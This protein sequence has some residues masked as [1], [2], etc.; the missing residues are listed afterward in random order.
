MAHSL[1]VRVPFLDMDVYEM[2]R[3][4]PHRM[5]FHHGITKYALRKAAEGI[6]PGQV[7]AR[8]KLGFPV[9]I[10]NW[11]REEDWYRQVREAFSGRRLPPIS[12][13]S[14]SYNCWRSTV[15]ERRT[16]AGKY[17]RFIAFCCGIGYTFHR[18][19][20]ICVHMEVMEKN[21][22]ELFLPRNACAAGRHG[23]KYGNG[24][25]NI[26]WYASGNIRG[27]DNGTRGTNRRRSDQDPD[28]RG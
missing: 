1:E 24:F 15:M 25:P 11:L 9:P 17:G 4:L 13:R 16:T 8:R 14:I 26:D 18:Y 28:H 27:M 19:I 10:R 21:V 3:R 6:L 7:S 2:A 22:K 20:D 12:I 5:K 23:G